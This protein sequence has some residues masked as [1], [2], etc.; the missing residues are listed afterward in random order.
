[1]THEWFP[2]QF[3]KIWIDQCEATE[4]IRDHFGLKN[5]LDYLIG[6]KL[7][8]FVQAAEKHPDFAAELPAF[9][10]E[11]NRLFTPAEIRDYLDHLEKTKY[12]A[13]REPEPELDV[14]VDDLGEED[15]EEDWLE[16]PVMGAEELLRFAR[17]CQLLQ[18]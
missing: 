17:V 7:F 10:A 12:L 3:Q 15:E 13:P 11:I 6:E 5:A 14:D 16:N 9:L 2:I 8:H 4:G 1:M 18:Q